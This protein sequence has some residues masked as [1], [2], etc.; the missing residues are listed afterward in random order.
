[1]IGELALRRT[2]ERYG[3]SFLFTGEYKNFRDDREEEKK[4]EIGINQETG[5]SEDQKKTPPQNGFPSGPH[6]HPFDA[7]YAY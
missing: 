7:H 4:S 1:V 5:G 3:C 2:S 6:I